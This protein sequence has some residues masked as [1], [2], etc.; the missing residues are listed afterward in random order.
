MIDLQVRDESGRILARG[1]RG[2]DWSQ[3][4]IDLDSS[5]YPMLAGICAYLDAIFN[6][7]QIPLLLG[8]LQRLPTGAVLTEQERTDI[9]RLAEVA[10]A[11][12]HR[13]LWFLGD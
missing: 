6:S 3:E 11:E 8:E 1:T 9:R 10:Q 13:Y 4:F 7:R 2:L 5:A 12:P